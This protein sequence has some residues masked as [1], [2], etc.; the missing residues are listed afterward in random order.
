MKFAQALSNLQQTVFH[1]C[2]F[3]ESQEF[4]VLG[5]RREE[6]RYPDPGNV[7]GF[8]PGSSR[9]FVQLPGLSGNSY[10]LMYASP[11]KRSDIPKDQF[12][13][14]LTCRPGFPVIPATADWKDTPAYPEPL[15]PPRGYAIQRTT[16]SASYIT[17][18]GETWEGFRSPPRPVF[19]PSSPYYAIKL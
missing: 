19:D 4:Q 10:N 18:N 17:W 5:F 7:T 12:C 13:H 9:G 11:R 14:P 6:S 3:L 15:P 16:G 2:R 1:L 8:H